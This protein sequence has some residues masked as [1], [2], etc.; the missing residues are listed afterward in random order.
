[1]PIE[2]IKK[3]RLQRRARTARVE[4]GEE[5][6]VRFLQ[7]DRRIEPRAETLRKSGLARTDR[8]FD[9]DVAELQGAR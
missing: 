9:R 3:L 1:M 8:S 5:R 7:H 2:E 6:I 4:V